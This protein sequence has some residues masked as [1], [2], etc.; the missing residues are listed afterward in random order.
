MLL[1]ANVAGALATLLVFF[2]PSVAFVRFASEYSAMARKIVH[3]S[4]QLL[5]TAVLL[6]TAVPTLALPAH[7]ALETTH[8]YVGGAVVGVII[9][10]VY[11]TRL[12]RFRRFHRTA[13]WTAAF[14]VCIYAVLAASL[15]LD[16]PALVSLATGAAGSFAALHVLS[17]CAKRT[18]MDDFVRRLP[19]GS[20]EVRQR[21]GDVVPVPVGAGWSQYLNKTTRQVSVPT[22]ALSG[23]YSQSTWGAGTSIRAVQSALRKEGKTL[24]SHP[25]VNG[26]TLGGWVFTDAHGSGGTAPADPF[27]RVVFLDTVAREIRRAPRSFFQTADV[28]RNVVILEVEVLSVDDVVCYRQAYDVRSVADCRRFL[29]EPSLLRM[30]FVDDRQTLCYSWTTQP[31]AA[32][33]H[34]YT[35]SFVPPWLAMLLPSRVSARIPRRWWS[36][37]TTLSAANS[38]AP[39]PPYW[40][41]AVARLY[42]NFEVFIDRPLTGAELLSLCTCLRALFLGELRGRCEVRY[43]ARVLFL[44]VSMTAGPPE[45]FFEALSRTLG[46]QTAVRVH[47]GKYPVDTRPL[48]RVRCHHV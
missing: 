29:S 7:G 17:R 16:R 42:T 2:L 15:H 38:F 45:R 48:R 41:G 46:A 31:P 12:P 40:T 39:D 26:A 6:A 27:G 9:P 11:V 5:G 37:Q 18:T 4:L 44:D 25:S 36:K 24:P 21:A 1:G 3:S 47:A 20:Y 43:H 8:R 22:T 35:D 30:I 10:F 14:G 34:R 32:G 13:G 28:R 33:L 23:R 19:D